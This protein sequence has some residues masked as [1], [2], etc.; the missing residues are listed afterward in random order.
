MSRFVAA[1]GLLVVLFATAGASAQSETREE[2]E[3]TAEARALFR[4]GMDAV[5]R[6]DWATAADRLGRSYELRPSPV[7]LYN[8]AGA[9][10]QLGRLV[11]ASEDLRAAIRASD[12]DSR[13][14]DLAE[15]RLAEVE[16]RLGTLQIDLTGARD[17]VQLML[18]GAPVPAPLLGVPQ[19]ADPGTH[20]VSVSRGAAELSARE[21]EVQSGQRATVSLEAP[22]A[23]GLSPEEVARSSVEPAR[24]NTEPVEPTESGGDDILTSWWFWTVIGVVVLGAAAAAITAASLPPSVMP[25]IQG[26]SQSVHTTLLEGL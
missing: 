13:L 24:L 21:V 7:V 17:G 12:D 23:V 15:R 14:H 4:E 18:D 11:E 5:D 26:D 6:S 22:P 9:L 10:A 19:P 1:A 3:R 20:R 8:L 2:T 25:P 16:A